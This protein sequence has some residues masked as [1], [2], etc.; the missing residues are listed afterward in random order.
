MLGRQPEENLRL[1]G[2]ASV[3]KNVFAEV[4]VKL[5]GNS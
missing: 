1:V 3:I 4:V 5:L 2:L